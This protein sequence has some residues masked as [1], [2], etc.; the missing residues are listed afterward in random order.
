MGA[1]SWGP[2]GKCRQLASGDVLVES[3][4]ELPVGPEANG[5][6]EPPASCAAKFLLVQHPTPILVLVVTRSLHGTPDPVVEH[7]EHD[8][9]SLVIEGVKLIPVIEHATSEPQSSGVVEIPTARGPSQ[10]PKQ[11]NVGIRCDI[12]VESV[13]GVPVEPKVIGQTANNSAAISG[14][15]LMAQ[16]QMSESEQVTMHL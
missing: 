12:L 2:R 9:H 7:T 8:A 6:A 14:I 16:A 3:V 5:E 13:S 10:G 15:E 1:A 11:R 4:S